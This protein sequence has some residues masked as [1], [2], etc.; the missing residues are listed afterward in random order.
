[1][2]IQYDV[3]AV[4]FGIYLY[5]FVSTLLGFILDLRIVF[6]P[7]TFFKSILLFVIVFLLSICRQNTYSH[8]V[9][10]LMILVLSII[11][12]LGFMRD[13]KYI[14]SISQQQHVSENTIKQVSFYILH[15]IINLSAI[16]ILSKHVF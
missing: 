1:M 4:I 12:T 16:I 7:V 13:Y 14:K 2:L 3:V 8:I 9:V 11:Q 6:I 5:L 15:S 10:I